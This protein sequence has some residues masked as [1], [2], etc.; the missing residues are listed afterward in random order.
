M[1]IGVLER[2]GEIGLRRAL[3]ATRRHISTQFLAE[4]MLLTFIGGVVGMLV[5]VSATALTSALQHEPLTVPPTALWVGAP[6]AV[7][8]GAI[9]GLYPALRA[10]RLPPTS[11]LREG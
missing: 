7:V 8:I 5:G 10:S 1:V 6:A 11:A 2:R 3:G 4:A 9:A